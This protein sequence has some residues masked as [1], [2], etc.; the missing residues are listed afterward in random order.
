MALHAPSTLRR[1]RL[2]CGWPIPPGVIECSVSTRVV[3]ERRYF[4]A[5]G[6]RFMCWECIPRCLDLASETVQVWEEGSTGWTGP[7]TCSLCG[8]Y[9]HVNVT[10]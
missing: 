3:T 8:A 2:P 7:C 1:A 10:P 5:E 6:D 4:V 9:I